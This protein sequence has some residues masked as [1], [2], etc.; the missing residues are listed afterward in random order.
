[1]VC[2]VHPLHPGVGR[3]VGRVS[4]DVP[5]EGGGLRIAED[6]LGSLPSEKAGTSLPQASSTRQHYHTAVR[7]SGGRASMQ[8]AKLKGVQHEEP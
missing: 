3:A 7:G 4:D 2:S 5:E 6:R 8:A 1:M